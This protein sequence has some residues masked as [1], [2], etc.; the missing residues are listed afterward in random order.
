VS[1]EV[2]RQ[3]DVFVRL[4]C[5]LIDKNERELY[6]WPKHLMEYLLL[7]LVQAES[8]PNEKIHKLSVL[9]LINLEH[10]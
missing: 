5:V 8:N 3:K 9:I 10:T 6:L 1:G 7:T 4:T 2:E